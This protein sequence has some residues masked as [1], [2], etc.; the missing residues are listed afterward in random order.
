MSKK[1]KLCFITTIQNTMDWFV[2]PNMENLANNGYDITLVCTMD[3]QF[4]TKVSHYAK[5]YNLQ[6]ERGKVGIFKMIRVIL[7]LRKFFK[8]EKFDIVEYATPNA[9]FYAS[10]AARLAGV[11][12]RVYNQWGIRYVSAKGLGRFILKRIEKITCHHSTLIRSPSNKN[13]E[14]GIKERL[15]KRKKVKVLGIGGTIGVVISEYDLNSKETSRKAIFEKYNIP[16]GAFIYGFVGRLNK[17]KGVNEL[18]LAFKEIKD[19]HTHLILVGME[20]KVNPIQADL[21]EWAK[22]SKR[23][24][25]VG[26]V[27]VNEVPSYLLSFDVL[28]H[29]TYREGFGKILQEAMAAQTAVITTDIPGPSEVVEDDISGILVPAK[30]VETLREKMIFLKN[31][32]EKRL[33]IAKNGR[34]RAE[35]YFYREYMMNNYLIDVNELTDNI[36]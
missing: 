12:V 24:V 27:P 32:D 1:K 3:G 11:K 34:I 6:M 17:D 25:I 31:D 30:N 16:Q 8:K 21:L 33:E 20:D 29:P 35:K 13:M 22:Q 5:T 4:Q 23:V 36:K 9:S 7:K 10:I 2:L 18:L 19:E 14:F 15:Y 28:V 26:Q